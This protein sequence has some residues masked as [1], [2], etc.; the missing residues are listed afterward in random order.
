MRR[1]VY[2]VSASVDGFIS[3]PDEDINGFTAAGNGVDKYLK[4]LEGY[5][6]VIMGRKTYEFGY[7]FG[8]ETGQL[9]YQHMVHF[10]FS[11]SLTFSNQHDSIHVVEANLQVIEEIRKQEGSDIYLCGGGQLAGWLLE[12]HQIDV[13]KIKLNPL[14]L[15]NG[16]RMFG[17]S[18]I[19]CNSLMLKVM[20]M[21]YR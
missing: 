9:A 14:I 17:N 21:A 6:T 7:K 13:L 3:G 1:I 12:E 5:D 11:S 19:T 8:L 10:I 16:V 20:I 15:G 18:E 2:Y 4:D